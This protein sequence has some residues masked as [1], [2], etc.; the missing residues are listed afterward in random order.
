MDGGSVMATTDGHHWPRFGLC[1]W[2]R[3]LKLHL[4]PRTSLL[5]SA[6]PGVPCCVWRAVGV[7]GK[8][9]ETVFVFIVALYICCNDPSGLVVLLITHFDTNEK[10]TP[11]W[12]MLVRTAE[13][14]LELITINDISNLWMF[15]NMMSNMMSNVLYCSHKDFIPNPVIYHSNHAPQTSGKYHETFYQSQAFRW[16]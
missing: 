11:V 12:E 6:W 2:H 8:R 14:N 1:V 9:D 3:T 16:W 7:F 10:P 4:P 5:A 15:Q 13:H